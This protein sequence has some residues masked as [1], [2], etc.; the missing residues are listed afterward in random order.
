M[1]K[2]LSVMFL[3]KFKIF[4]YLQANAHIGVFV[5]DKVEI[6]WEGEIKRKFK[7]GRKDERKK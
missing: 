5:N 1:T 7:K 3:D 4:V 6:D 2:T